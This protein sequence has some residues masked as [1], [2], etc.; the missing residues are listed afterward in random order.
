MQLM[1]RHQNEMLSVQWHFGLTQEVFQNLQINYPA[2][3]EEITSRFHDT[4]DYKLAKAQWWLILQ[5]DR[6]TLKKCVSN[7][8]DIPFTTYSSIHERVWHHAWAWNP[9]LPK[10]AQNFFSLSSLSQ[11]LCFTCFH[12]H[13]DGFRLYVDS[14]CM[15]DEYYL[16]GTLSLQ[17]EGDIVEKYP[18]LDDGMYFPV[19]SR[20][21][22]FLCITKQHLYITLLASRQR[23]LDV[24]Q[25]TQGYKN[26]S[27]SF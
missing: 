2:R 23:T 8:T 20:L 6:W 19:R 13:D 16:V 9:P 25:G 3:K 27:L 11:L 26:N 24:C 1:E 22:E 21:A 14:T 18:L 15:R 4:I 10:S 12:F 17:V 7:S 5:N